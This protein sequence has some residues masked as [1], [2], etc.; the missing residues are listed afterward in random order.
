MSE[1]GTLDPL[2]D[3]A[4]DVTKPA[5]FHSSSF[6]P[7]PEIHISF[8]RCANHKR[9]CSFEVKVSPLN[10]SQNELSSIAPIPK[11][12]TPQNPTSLESSIK[13]FKISRIKKKANESSETSSAEQGNNSDQSLL[14]LSQIGRSSSSPKFTV[15]ITEQL[16]LP[17]QAVATNDLIEF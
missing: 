3:P 6:E 5:S 15:N 12:V 11:F 17:P 2:Y 8:N 4:A 7:I 13:K 10:N 1:W 9:R 16:V 14:S